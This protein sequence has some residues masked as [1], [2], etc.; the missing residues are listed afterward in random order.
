[1]IIWGDKDK[2]LHV[3]NAKLFHKYIKNS[4]LVVLKGIGHMPM[5]ESATKSAKVFN[6]FIK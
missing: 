3:D 1:L 2:I 4:K 6:D 5:L